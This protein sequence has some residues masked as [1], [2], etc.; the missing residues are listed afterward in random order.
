MRCF[1]L[2]GASRLQTVLFLIR[3][4]I[5]Y[6]WRL[7]PLKTPHLTQKGTPLS[8]TMQWVGSSLRVP[9]SPDARPQN[10]PGLF[11]L[12]SMA[13]GFRTGLFDWG[14]TVVDISPR[15]FQHRQWK[16]QQTVA[17]AAAT[18]ATAIP[19]TVLK[20]APAAA[21]MILSTVLQYW[22]Q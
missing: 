10:P 18:E 6:I 12:A 22:Y 2:G 16:C 9:K 20:I 5:P 8:A 14:R 4:L 15:L 21:A 3:R 11:L 1:L 13:S 7:K 19:L 17:F